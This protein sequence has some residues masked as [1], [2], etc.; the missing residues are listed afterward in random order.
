MDKPDF[1]LEPDI[2]KGVSSGTITHSY[3][4]PESGED[5][6]KAIQWM[7]TV[8]DDVYC[9]YGQEYEIGYCNLEGA[10]R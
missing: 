2:W 8:Y 9:D 3:T 6:I 7:M 10:V 5:I 1:L 4:M